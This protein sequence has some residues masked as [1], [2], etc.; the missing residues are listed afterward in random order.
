MEMGPEN[1]LYYFHMKSVD[2]ELLASK[3]HYF[4]LEMWKPGSVDSQQSKGCLGNATGHL[5]IIFLNSGLC[6]RPRKKEER[7]RR[8][9]QSPEKSGV[10]Q[11]PVIPA[12]LKGMLEWKIRA[13]FG[14]AIQWE[15]MSISVF[16]TNLISVRKSF[17]E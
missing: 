4:S 3:S 1:S 9:A 13:Y 11:L 5:S 8:E 17:T 12:E 6:S 15:M 7:S 16:V 2:I 14:L 10:C